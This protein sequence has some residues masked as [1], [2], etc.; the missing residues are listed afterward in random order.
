[1]KITNSFKQFYFLYMFKLF[2]NL[3]SGLVKKLSNLQVAIFLLLLIA[4]FSAFG[5]IIEQDKD[6]PFYEANYPTSKPVFG[7]VTFK[8]ILFFGLDNIYQTSWFIFLL[9]LFGCS[10]LSCTISTQLPSLRLAQIWQFYKNRNILQKFELSFCLKDVNLS[11][12]YFQLYSHNYNVIQQGPFLYAYK[13]LVGK[14]GPIIVHLSIIIILCGAILG[15]VAGFTTQ[16]LV[17]VKRIFHLQN[18]ISSGFLS[19]V[20]PNYVGYVKDF[21]ITYSDEGNID[22]FYSDLNIFKLEDKK[23]ALKTIYVNEPL[24]TGG[25]T[26]YQTDW[27]LFSVTVNVDNL[28]NFQL[29]LKLVSVSPSSRFWIS[30]LGNIKALNQKESGLFA[31][32]EDLT[33][34][35]Q[36]FDSN[37]NLLLESEIGST[38]FING[39]KIQIKEVTPLTG[40]QIKADPGINIVYFGF[41]LLILSTFLSYTSYSQIWAIKKDEY[42]YLSGRTNRAIYSFEKDFLNLL[43]SIF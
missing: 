5:T 42:L 15:N 30:S 36:I 19:Y 17:P 38:F 14:L 10:L 6:I 31:V 33:G 7:F 18:V 43:E 29:P 26:F 1:L 39:Y 8:L 34:K 25:L 2:N 40:L 27:S 16:E 35:F 41:T 32:F 24:K 3:F 28:G 21:R 11:K 12:F 13:G 9:L 22:Q 4:L 23:K 37:Q 20:D